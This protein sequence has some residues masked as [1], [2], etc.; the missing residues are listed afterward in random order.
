VFG[1][2]LLPEGSRD[3]RRWMWIG[4]FALLLS[5]AWLPWHVRMLENQQRAFT[6][7]AHLYRDL[8]STAQA[9][10]VLAALRAC[11]PLSTADHRPIPYFRFWAD[12]PP[13]SV[14]TVRGN[15]SPLGQVFL[16]PRHTTY[17]TRFYKENF[18]TAVA[19]KRYE[20]IYQN[21]SY[22]VSASP[23]CVAKLGAAA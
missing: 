8:R 21:R 13:G 12:G 9:P 1:W 19:P 4:A 7:D 22:R 17:A 18:P 14:G 2:R 23:A 3:R 16:Q 10:A 11:G 5:I 20:R 15:A 6:R